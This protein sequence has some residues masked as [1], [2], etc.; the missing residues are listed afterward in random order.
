M[1]ISR[2]KDARRQ[3]SVQ[4]LPPKLPPHTKASE[5][6]DPATPAGGG[7]ALGML[8]GEVRAILD[9]ARNLA[10]F[11]NARFPATCEERACDLARA[12]QRVRPRLDDAINVVDGDF[13]DSPAAT[14]QKGGA[15]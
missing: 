7:S 10:L 6:P 12:I 2:A 1:A 3:R 15:A 9:E 14:A 4:P 5:F 11:V 8:L 13:D